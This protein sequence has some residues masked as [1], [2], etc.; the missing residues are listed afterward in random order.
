MEGNKHAC[1]KSD[2][3]TYRTS[4]LQ[5]RTPPLIKC[6]NIILC[7]V[8]GFKIKY[9]VPRPKCIILIMI[10]FRTGKAGKGLGKGPPPS[11][12]GVPRDPILEHPALHPTANKQPAWTSREPSN[13][14]G[15]VWLMGRWVRYSIFYYQFPL[16]NKWKQQHAQCASARTLRVVTMV[17]VT[18]LVWARTL[19]RGVCSSVRAMC[20]G[21]CGSSDSHDARAARGAADA[22]QQLLYDTAPQII[23]I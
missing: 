2:M 17:T 8:T 7:A 23:F 21:G 1:T 10:M 14:V 13:T 18:Q 22:S 3:I 9:C 11:P 6:N 5:S 12:S 20:G 16:P 19:R 4:E 15:A